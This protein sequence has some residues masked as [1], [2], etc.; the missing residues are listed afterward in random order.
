MAYDR[1]TSKLLIQA[2]S[3][4][5]QQYHC[6]ESDKDYNGDITQFPLF[7]R[8]FS[9]YTQVTNFKS[10]D[11]SLEGM[12]DEYYDVVQD[13]YYDT[14]QYFYPWLSDNESEYKPAKYFSYYGFLLKSNQNNIIVFRGAKTKFEQT[15][16]AKFD[17]VPGSTFLGKI[18]S[19]ASQMYMKNQYNKR[20]LQD[21]IFPWV[22]KLDK[23]IPC[24]IAAHSF[25]GPF[26]ILTALDLVETHGISANNVFM[27]NYG[28]NSV[29][30]PAFASFY[31]AKVPNS[32]RVVNIED[33]APDYPRK[34][35]LLQEI[36]YQHVGQEWSF[37]K[38]AYPFSNEDKLSRIKNHL[39]M[40][41]YTKN[42]AQLDPYYTAVANQQENLTA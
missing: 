17:Q 33:Y 23:D 30:D 2:I 7:Q 39:D 28:A 25:G 35:M 20:S 4:A 19:G 6:W 18:Y 40:V 42:E 21:Q 14:L 29:G 34:A 13:E 26:A 16:A 5:Y 37:R 15:Q 9:N 24:Y 3:L 38:E 8:V 12:M 41:S 22:E 36:I 10:Y 27:Y 1:N 11:F 31:N 32:Y